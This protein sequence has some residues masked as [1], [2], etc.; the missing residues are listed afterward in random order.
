MTLT[1]AARRTTVAGLLGLTIGLAAALPATPAFARPPRY[2]F[3]GYYVDANSCETAGQDYLLSHW[4]SGYY[5]Q[6]SNYIWEL[7]VV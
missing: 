2:T 1:K 4:N 6:E 3:Q 5:C 7:W